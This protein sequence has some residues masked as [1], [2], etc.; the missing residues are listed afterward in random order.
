MSVWQPSYFWK[1]DYTLTRVSF[2]YWGGWYDG[3]GHMTWSPEDGVRIDAFL[4]RKGPPLPPKIEFPCV[5]VARRED[6]RSLRLH[7]HHNGWAVILLASNRS[8]K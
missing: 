3:R 7:L 5:K 4:D 2:E 1:Q 6:M 8:A